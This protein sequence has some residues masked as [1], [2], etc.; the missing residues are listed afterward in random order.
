MKDYTGEDNI[1]TDRCILLCACV[2]VCVC[3]CVCEADVPKTC[4]MAAEIWG[5][6]K[7]KDQNTLTVLI[8]FHLKHTKGPSTRGKGVVVFSI[9]NDELD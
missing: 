2:C 3:V 7:G 5:Y 6:W 4:K 8:L 1:E 9:R